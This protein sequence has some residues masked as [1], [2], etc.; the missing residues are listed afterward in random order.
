M[1]LSAPSIDSANMRSEPGLAVEQADDD[2]SWFC[3]QTHPKH[4][5]IAAAGLAKIGGFEV[6][7]PRIRVRR[8]TKRGPV[9][10]VESAFPR[11]VFVRF[12]LKL[13][14]DT[15][16]YFSSVSRVVHFQSG[17]PSI[18]EAQLEE[19][20][21]IFGPEDTLIYDTDVSVGDSVR[22]VGGAFHDLVA[23][24]Q[25]VRPSQQRVQALLE[26]LGRITTVEVDIH[27]LVVVERGQQ[28]RPIVGSRER[29]AGIAFVSA[30]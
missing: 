19:L 3:I 2:R 23:I 15:V 16:R 14:I 20:R 22:I 18:P 12:D 9:W 11:Y 10:F 4:E 26:F 30:E 29:M 13:H 7:N 1:N 27:N 6:F 28:M 8:A 24:V 21:G 17:Y 5:H 25:Q